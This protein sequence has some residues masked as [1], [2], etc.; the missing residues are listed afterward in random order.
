MG[1]SVKKGTQNYFN[2]TN[3]IR[4]KVYQCSCEGKPDNKRSVGK[5][6]D[7]KKMV[8][9][10]DCKA[11]LRVSRE[12]D[13]PWTICRFYKEHNHELLS[14]DQSYLLRLAR[15]MSHAKKS[16]LEA[17][18]SAG[19]GVSRA[20]RYMEKES[21]GIMNVGFTR[22]DAYAHMD[23]IK[24]KTK[25][26]NGDANELLQFFLNKSNSEPLFFWNVQLDD[27]GRLMNFFFHDSRCAVDYDY[28]GDVL[29]VNTTYR[30]NK[31]NLVCVPFIGINDHCN[32]VMFGLSFLSDET[33]KSFEWLFGTF[34][35]SMSGKEPG[36]IFSDQCQA[37][38][39]G[40]DYAFRTSSH[41]LCQWHI[42]QNAPSH[43][44]SL[45][46]NN[47]FKKLWHHC[48]N[49]CENE[50]EFEQ[51]WQNLIDTYDL[52]EN[53]WFNSIY[54][55]RRRWSSV[56]TNSR[57][58]AGLHATSRS[59]VMNKI[60]KDLC[61]ASGSLYEFVLQYEQVQNDWRTRESTEDALCMNVPGQYVENNPL[62]MHAAKVFTR[63]VYK[64]FE[65]E[66]AHAINIDIIQKPVDYS[67]DDLEFQVAAN[68][69]LSRT[70]SVLFN[71]KMHNTSCTRHLWESQ[72]VLCS[73]IFQVLMS[74]N[75]HRL[76][77]QCIL[78]RWMKDAKLRN[79]YL[80]P[81]ETQSN[82]REAESGMAFVNYIMRLTYDFAQDSKDDPQAKFIIKKHISALCDEL[83]ALK[84]VTPPKNTC[85]NTKEKIPEARFRNPPNVKTRGLNH[86]TN[87]S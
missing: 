63:N 64:K 13:G 53:R 40:I 21:G 49:E 24:K 7:Y 38:M 14:P 18:N 54:N 15:N 6:A 22:K 52:C 44:G 84:G 20:F 70:R 69:D 3:E 30:T 37:L 56:F 81:R 50:D 46:G 74:M 19:I 58:S 57:F 12:R 60:L 41:R 82:G 78:K 9:R 33:T 32:I 17:L 31:Y 85:S 59:E 80:T 5:L 73:H 43:F 29:S 10:T 67:V 47:E 79:F 39:N 2:K 65:S 66:V 8:T 27:E 28:F 25:V 83:C 68:W 34:L 16:I 1:F 51:S 77:H 42:N 36:V 48:M 11:M 55:L 4:M 72:G 87:C 71:Q 35:E 62:L 75:V 26:E 23:R 61:S 76:P 45:N 86:F